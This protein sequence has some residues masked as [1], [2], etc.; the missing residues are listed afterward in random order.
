MKL[1]DACIEELNILE[2]LSRSTAIGKEQIKGIFKKGLNTLLIYP[3]HS[4]DD[5]TFTLKFTSIKS[6]RQALEQYEEE[7]RAWAGKADV[8][9]VRADDTDVLRQVF[10]NYFVDSSDFVKFINRGLRKMRRLEAQDISHL[11]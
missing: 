11:L 6:T 7:E 5:K 8:V 2:I 4:D 1:Y 10:Q 9:L 3:Y